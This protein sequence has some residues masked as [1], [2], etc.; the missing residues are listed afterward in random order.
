MYYELKN[1]PYYTEPTY[2]PSAEV[3]VLNAKF[4]TGV[5]VIVIIRNSPQILINVHLKEKKMIDFL[6]KDSVVHLGN[7]DS[8]SKML[9]LSIPIDLFLHIVH[10]GQVFIKIGEEVKPLVF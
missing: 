2:V 6:V 5:C 4:T 10:E 8:I 3:M 1:L 9:K 7:H